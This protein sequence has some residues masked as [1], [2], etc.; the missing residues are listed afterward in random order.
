MDDQAKIAKTL[1]VFDEYERRFAQARQNKKLRSPWLKSDREEILGTVK[2]VLK[3][4][5]AMIPQIRVLDT[6]TQVFEGVEVRH[7]LFESW[8]SF[9]GINSLY[10][11]EGGGKKPLVVICPGHAKTGRFGT[12]Y[13][14]MAL[15]LARQGAYA[16]VLENIGQG[17]RQAFGHWM[18][19]EVFYCKKNLQGLILAESCACIRYMRQQPFVDETKIGACGNSGGGTLTTFLCALEPSLTAIASCG[20]PNEFTYLLQ[21]EKKH[22]DCNLLNHVAGR[23]EMWEVHSLFAPKPLLLESGIYDNLLPADL[24]RKNSRKVQTVYDMLGAGEKFHSVPAKTKH[25]WETEDIEAIGSFFADYFD[26]AQPQAAPEEPLL[27]HEAVTLA[28]PADAVTTGQ[29]VQKLTGITAPEGLT[30]PDIVK[31]RF[32]GAELEADTVVPML[33]KSEVMRIL[34]QYEFS[35]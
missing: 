25:S 12:G 4:D 26:L 8:P 1:E 15:T 17:S 33:G 32:R 30:L 14:R 27:T 10:V 13:Q 11:P 22:C 35:L 18:V 7:Q 6:Q 21:K 23:L 20:Y 19:P 28:F 16:L 34:A 31:P 29:M 2:D 5:D 3:F 9:Y 24:F